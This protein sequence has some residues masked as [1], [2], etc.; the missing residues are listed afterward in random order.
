MF[1]S[2]D[3]L[4]FP[5]YFTAVT[6]E[7]IKLASLE[8]VAAE[9]FPRLS[10]FLVDLLKTRYTELATL[11]MAKIMQKGNLIMSLSLKL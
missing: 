7:T 10:N 8:N 2:I 9:F 11:F 3:L 6:Y 5:Y 1:L 4:Y